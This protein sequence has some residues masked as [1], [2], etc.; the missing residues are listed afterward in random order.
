MND[1]CTRTMR[2]TQRS[3]RCLELGLKE[4][5]YCCGWRSLSAT[6][7][8]WKVD[9]VKRKKQVSTTMEEG[10]KARFGMCPREAMWYPL[11]DPEQRKYSIRKKP[12]CFRVKFE[13]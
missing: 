13:R 10:N 4:A 6:S 7:R 9:V 11:I 1:G 8:S 3:E 2:T 12:I 5:E